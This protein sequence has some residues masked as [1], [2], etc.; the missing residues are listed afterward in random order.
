MSFPFRSMFLCSL[1]STFGLISTFLQPESAN[2]ASC[3]TPALSRIQRHQVTRGET[4]ESI[5]QGYK[6]MPATIINMN[7]SIN[8]GTVTA[9]TQLQ[10]PPFNGT[11]VEVPREQ[12]WRQVAARYKVRPDTLF[13]INGCQQNPRVV[14][15]PVV[16]GVIAS[17]NR[18]IAASPT[19]TAPSATIAGYPLPNGTTVALAYG[20][21]IEPI[22]GKV[23]FHSGVDLV[24]PVGTTVEAIAPGIVVFAKD[25]GSYGKLV[26]INHIGGYQSRYAQLETI[27][28]TL[29]Q[30][31]KAG[32][33][34]GTVGTTGTPTSREPHLHFEIRFNG[35]LGWEAKDPK[36]YFTK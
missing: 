27:N 34:I 15:V 20:W 9:G 2:A 12:T 7:P 26:I 30:M 19:Q 22:S 35:S 1:V 6:L 3:Q 4:V 36:A 32:E 5:A 28:V 29:G 13:E 14:F 31:I 21:Q 17:P 18:I 23:F 33:T 11:V 10:I 8:N 25:Q 16:P 24:A